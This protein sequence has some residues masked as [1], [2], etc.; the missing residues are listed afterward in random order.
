MTDDTQLRSW[1]TRQWH[2]KCSSD[3][4]WGNLPNLPY[5]PQHSLQPFS[6]WRRLFCPVHP[7]SPSMCFNKAFVFEALGSSP[8]RGLM[9]MS[10]LERMKPWSLSRFAHCRCLKVTMAYVL[11]EGPCFVRLFEALKRLEKVVKRTVRQFAPL[12]S[13]VTLFQS[14]SIFFIFPS[15]A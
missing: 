3:F 4:H 1:A 12:D 9:L 6:T 15:K 13:A 5:N 14:T 8:G 11:Q 2:W 10:E 7:C